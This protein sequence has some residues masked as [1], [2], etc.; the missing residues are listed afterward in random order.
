MFAPI[1]G[2]VPGTLIVLPLHQEVVGPTIPASV[3]APQL[4]GRHG[5]VQD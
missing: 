2:Y 1:L 3:P 5:A 4:Q